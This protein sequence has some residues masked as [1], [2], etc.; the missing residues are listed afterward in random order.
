MFTSIATRRNTRTAVVAAAAAPVG[1]RKRRAAVPAQAPAR[2]A[3]RAAAQR[4]AHDDNVLATTMANLDTD[5]LRAKL[6]VGEQVPFAVRACLPAFCACVLLAVL[7][8]ERASLW[9][10]PC[11]ATPLR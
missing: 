3:A 7:V 9:R 2:P 6:F 11:R 10:F 5:K 1:A 8:V 4:G